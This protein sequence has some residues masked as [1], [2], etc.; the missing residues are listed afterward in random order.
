MS[1]KTLLA[2]GAALLAVPVAMASPAG[3]SSRLAVAACTP[4]LTL[5]LNGTAASAPTLATR[6]A[7]ATLSMNVTSM[8]PTIKA[9][10]RVKTLVGQT[11][12][13]QVSSRTKILRNNV[14]VTLKSIKSGDRLNVTAAACRSTLIK[15]GSPIGVA[16]LIIVRRPAPA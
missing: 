3:S 14:A 8:T 9:N 2:L 1:W 11:V 15:G 12:V 7:A 13:V 16:T 5:H 10:P 4:D 6:K